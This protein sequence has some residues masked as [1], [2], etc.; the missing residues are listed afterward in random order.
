LSLV[1]SQPQLARGSLSLDRNIPSFV[2]TRRAM[3][4]VRV[5]HFPFSDKKWV[6][7]IKWAMTI[8]WVIQI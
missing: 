3:Q 1:G 7:R 5:T 4:R 2:I 8:V 6:A